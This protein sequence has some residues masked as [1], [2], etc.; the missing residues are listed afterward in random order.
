MANAATKRKYRRR[1]GNGRSSVGSVPHGTH[2]HHQRNGFTDR[3]VRALGER[4]IGDR[5]ERSILP[6]HYSRGNILIWRLYEHRDCADIWRL[7]SFPNQWLQRCDPRWVVWRQ[8]GPQPDVDATAE[9]GSC[10]QCSPRTGLFVEKQRSHPGAFHHPSDHVIFVHFDT[11]AKS[12]AAMINPQGAIYDAEGGEVSSL[13]CRTLET[14]R[15]RGEQSYQW[16]YHQVEVG[17]QW[18]DDFVG[19]KLLPTTPIMR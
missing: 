2:A 9:V 12:T 13:P 8:R 7:Q 6:R 18:E 16:R 15:S 11:R 1:G 5:R 14:C 17:R 4:C 10:V 19:T 3:R